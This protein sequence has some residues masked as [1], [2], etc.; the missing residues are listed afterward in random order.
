MHKPRYWRPRERN[1]RLIADECQQCGYVSFPEKQEICKRCRATP[2]EWD[3]VRL[4]ARGVVQSYV[5][6]Q[7]LSDA[8]EDP[9][10]LAVIDVPQVEEGEAARVFGLFTETDPDD[11]EIGLEVEAD[12]REVFEVDGL[13]V[14]SYK[15]KLPRTEQS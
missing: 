10:P 12:F 6:Q 5:V 1:E 8:F 4:Q 2:S 11:I 14:H 7:R 9:L 15:F 13:P 3:T